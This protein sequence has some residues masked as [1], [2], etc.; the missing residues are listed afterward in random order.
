MGLVM[1]DARFADVLKTL[2]TQL[3]N[4]GYLVISKYIM[5]QITGT[6][7]LYFSVE[8]H[9]RFSTQTVVLGQIVGAVIAAPGPGYEVTGVFFKP[10]AQPPGGISVGNQ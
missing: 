4:N 1:G 8:E 10:A 5:P 2:N 7:Y 9:I 6:I 3:P